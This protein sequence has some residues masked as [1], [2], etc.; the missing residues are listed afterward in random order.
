MYKKLRLYLSKTLI[1]V[2]ITLI[3]LILMK[4]S[5]NFKVTFY[6]YVYDT[7]FSFSTI[8][9][10]YNKYFGALIKIPDKSIETVFNEKLTYT[11]KQPYQ[12]GVK[13]S[14]DK[15]YMVPIQLS[16][17]V[18]F[19]GEKEGY[20]NVVIIEQVNGVDMW[21]GNIS[22]VNVKLYDYVEKGTLLGEASDNLYLVY[23]KNGN[24]LDYDAYL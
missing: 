23:K 21:Y 13:L 4:A 19:I 24:I 5:N 17:I 8:N 9:N 10:I 16:G 6:K 11:D 3:V 20:G 18:V 2:I 22:T 7:N 12:D 15:N 1:T 14:I